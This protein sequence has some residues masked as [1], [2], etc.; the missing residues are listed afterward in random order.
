MIRQGD[1]YWAD[2]DQP[3]GSEPGYRHP[4][5]VI[6]NDL[7]NNI[8]I[9]TVIVCMITSN[10]K[11]ARASGNVLLNEGEANLAKPSVVNVTQ[12]NPRNSQRPQSSV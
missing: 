9:K 10:Q 7:F 3:R 6:Q 12:A 2:F 8:P 11:Y 5:V 1:L 4:V